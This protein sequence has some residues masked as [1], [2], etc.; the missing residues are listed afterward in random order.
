MELHLQTI[1]PGKDAELRIQEHAAQSLHVLTPFSQQLRNCPRGAKG[2]YRHSLVESTKRFVP[3]AIQI[4]AQGFV[5][6]QA[7][8]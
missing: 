3:V 1:S 2:S 6:R 5:F 7:I 4:V 8:T